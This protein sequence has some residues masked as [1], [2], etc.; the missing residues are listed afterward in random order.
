MPV[1]ERRP[2]RQPDAPLLVVQLE[3]WVDAGL[4]A[5]TATAALLEGR[6]AETV[7]DF[8]ADT[9]IDYRAR[10]PVVRIVDGVNSGLTWRVPRLL[11]TQDR[12]GRD[13]L[14][15]VGPEPDMKWQAF[16]TD[17]VELAR[18]LGV[19]MAVGLG[20]FPA[21]VP[22][23]RPVRIAATATDPAMA[24]RVGFVAGTIEV[25]AGVQAAL[26]LA[27]SSAGI[28]AVGLW[29]RVPHYVSGMPY[30]AGSAALLSALAQA[31]DITLD[32]AALE[33]AADAARGRVDELIA[34]SE[35]HRSMVSQL[36]AS[37]DGAEGTPLDLG[38]IPSGDEIAAELQRFL[39][40]EG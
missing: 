19:R 17:V 37:V 40:G 32:T 22:H 18:E 15:L 7:A 1:Y 34:A 8:D 33:T 13:L 6:D 9:L 12:A 29:A 23:T 3:G 31:G 11:L 25:P 21:P 27:M 5:A 24:A 16:V 20:A 38:E 14:L 26:E 28:P 35:E 10:R 2:A 4:A 39:R 36:E 30:P